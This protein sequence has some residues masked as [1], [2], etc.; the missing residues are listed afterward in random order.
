MHTS[1]FDH[2]F[3]K[4]ALTTASALL[5][6]ACSDDPEV[7]IADINFVDSNLG[8]CVSQYATD[9]N[10]EFAHE[11]TSLT[12]SDNKIT[13]LAGLEK[14][15]ALSSLTVSNNLFTDMSP[16]SSL[17]SLRTVA[18]GT[19]LALDCVQ[20]SAQTEILRHSSL[21]V[22]G[23]CTLAHGEINDD[24]SSELKFNNTGDDALLVHEQ[25][26]LTL[27][28]L[29]D[30]NDDDELLQG[31][32]S[33]PL[34]ESNTAAGFVVTFQTTINSLNALDD[35]SLTTHFKN[36]HSDV[37]APPQGVS[38][39]LVALDFTFDQSLTGVQT[40]PV[41]IGY[42]YVFLNNKHD[43]DGIIELSGE[44]FD[45]SISK[46]NAAEDKTIEH[47]DMD[48]GFTVSQAPTD[49]LPQTSIVVSGPGN[50]DGVI[51]QAEFTFDRVAINIKK[52]VDAGTL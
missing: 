17:K 15:T 6:S 1:K 10:L 29:H 46:D 21:T 32:I 8:Q 35:G 23:F 33:Y 36:L 9:S 41:E 40:S 24:F 45:F 34:T 2:R 19:N 16:L 51:N 14:L 48:L 25:A 39:N 26:T 30:Q 4:L 43:I 31:E 13:S 37:Q 44:T 5:L 22:T 42:D 11:I 28:S 20:V 47:L 50:R 38:S 3:R 18:I 12:C 27:S 52:I 49:E 7:P